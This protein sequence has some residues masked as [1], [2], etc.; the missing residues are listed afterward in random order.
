MT[1]DR[2]ALYLLCGLA[3]AGKTTLAA[4]IRERLGC[5]VVSYDELAADRGLSLR[6][7]VPP[8]R[9]A[10][11][12]RAALAAAAALLRAGQPRLVVDDTSCFRFL[13]DDWRELA[14]RHGRRLELLV[15]AASE[16]EVRRRMAADLADPSRP[17]LAP[18]VFDRHA[19][20]FQWPGEDEP[21]RT[22]PADAD[23]RDWV[24]ANLT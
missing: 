12:H 16:T 19:A 1:P 20:E 23:P 8:E 5:P 2:G 4:A 3:F 13:R 15:V 24:A 7:G 10:A 11:V 17:G 18:G 9:A 21:H 22:V 14:G 6:Q